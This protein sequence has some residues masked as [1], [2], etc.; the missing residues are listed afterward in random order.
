MR[1]GAVCREH[2]VPRGSGEQ[3]RSP[4][5][6]LHKQL[7]C[8]TGLARNGE[9]GWKILLPM[10]VWERTGTSCPPAEAAAWEGARGFPA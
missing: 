9:L 5:T 7:S 4:Q 6:R 10:A 1:A 2:Q 3:C 8:T